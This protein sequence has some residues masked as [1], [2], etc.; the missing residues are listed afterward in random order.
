M[1]GASGIACMVPYAK[2]SAILSGYS[3]EAN[4][5]DQLQARPHRAKN[6]FPARVIFIIS[7][8]VPSLP[9]CT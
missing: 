6:V 8:L 5:G 4:L 1:V 3:L 2:W 7:C 9:S